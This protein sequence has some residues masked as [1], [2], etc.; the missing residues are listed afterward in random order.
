MEKTILISLDKSPAREHYIS[1]TFLAVSLFLFMM[2]YKIQ[3]PTC[4]SK[5]GASDSLYIYIFHPLFL[6]ALPLLNRMPLAVGACYEY[7]APAVVLF[8]TM[9]FIVILRKTKLIK[10]NSR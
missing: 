2:S 10:E 3:K 1:T 6:F 4:I 5:I 7:V 8:L 9:T